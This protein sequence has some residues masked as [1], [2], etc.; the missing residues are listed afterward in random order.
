MVL[1]NERCQLR[2][3]TP[4]VRLLCDVTIWTACLRHSENFNEKLK[5]DGALNGAPAAWK[6]ELLQF[7]GS[8]GAVRPPTEITKKHAEVHRNLAEME[9]VN[10]KV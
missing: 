1:E 9:S 7:C 4:T 3:R 5:L 6:K 2:R 10:N 8:S